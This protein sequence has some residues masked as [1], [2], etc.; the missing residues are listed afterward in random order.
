MIRMGIIGVLIFLGIITKYSKFLS[1]S[2]KNLDF[3]REKQ[4]YIYLWALQIGGVFF[5]IIS[6]VNS[7]MINSTVILPFLILTGVGLSYIKNFNVLSND[8]KI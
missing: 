3:C 6:I 5:L 7:L 1:I 4:L 2:L 8:R